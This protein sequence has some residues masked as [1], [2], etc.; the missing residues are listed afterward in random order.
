MNQAHR[1]SRTLSIGI[2]IA[3]LFI[4]M[5]DPQASGES[6]F[7]AQA[8]YDADAPFTPRSLFTQPRPQNVGDIVTIIVNENL[9][10][11]T[12]LQFRVT[13]SQTL[14]ENG[15]S[16]FNNVA[17][18]FL[19]KIPGVDG[20]KMKD[21]VPSFSG[22]DNENNIATQAQS[23]KTVQYNDSITCQ[24]VQVLPNGHLL[25]QG[26]KSTMFNK[27]RS[28]L[29]VTG[30]INPYFIDK[31]NTISSQKVANFQFLMGGKGVISRQQVDGLYSKLGQF[32]N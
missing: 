31:N 21:F 28:D 1:I 14:T 3:S 18:F 24:I 4:T 22:L 12:T 5:V 11:N 9:K 19:G 13:K 23:N 20:S 17:K 32:F 8:A 27:E 15:T 29:Y 16:I 30:I 25:V 26:K 7:R 10:Q 6:L 2:C